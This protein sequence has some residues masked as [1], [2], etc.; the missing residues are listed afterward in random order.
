MA[1]PTLTRRRYPALNQ[2]HGRPFSSR[3]GRPGIAGELRTA[4]IILITGP[5][6]HPD[7]AGAVDLS[8]DLLQGPTR[9]QNAAKSHVVRTAGT[10]PGSEIQPNGH[11]NNPPAQAIQRRYE[12]IGCSAKGF[13]SGG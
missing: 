6:G 3:G 12:G 1:L 4:P 10:G 2:R 5:R 13:R 7:V 9:L 11:P 8:A